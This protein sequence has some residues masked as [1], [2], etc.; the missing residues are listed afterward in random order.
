MAQAMNVK[1]SFEPDES[2]VLIWGEFHAFGTVVGIATQPH[3][4]FAVLTETGDH[5]LAYLPALWPWPA[6]LAARRADL[7]RR[8]GRA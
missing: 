7:C 2:V 6:A 3:H 4:A 8:V 1:T 5:H